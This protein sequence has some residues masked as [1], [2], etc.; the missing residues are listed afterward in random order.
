MMEL[1]NSP[2]KRMSRDFSIVKAHKLQQSRCKT[3]PFDALVEGRLRTKHR[4]SEQGD[5]RIQSVTMCHT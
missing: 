1:I 5:P 3:S 2:F 4:D